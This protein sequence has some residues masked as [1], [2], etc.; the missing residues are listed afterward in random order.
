[1]PMNLRMRKLIG[2]FGLAALI[3]IYALLA[4]AIASNYVL[5]YNAAVQAVYFIV[6]GLL[7]MPLAMAL[8]WWVQNGG[9]R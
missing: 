9:R 3:T 6:A 7:W 1:M 5:Q 4:M 2:G 8:I